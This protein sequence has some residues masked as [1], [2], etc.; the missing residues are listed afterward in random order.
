MYVYGTKYG[1]RYLSHTRAYVNLNI[2]IPFAVPATLSMVFGKTYKLINAR[3]RT[4]FLINYKNIS[5][6]ESIINIKTARF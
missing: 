4:H 1:W 3:I 2:Y 5:M 6:N